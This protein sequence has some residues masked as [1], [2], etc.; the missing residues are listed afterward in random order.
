MGHWDSATRPVHKRV[1]TIPGL[2]NFLSTQSSNNFFSQM[3]DQSFPFTSNNQ[4]LK[5]LFSYVHLEQ[6]E[7]NIF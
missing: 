4:F 3:V 2:Q 7:I 1:R 6:P 5:Y